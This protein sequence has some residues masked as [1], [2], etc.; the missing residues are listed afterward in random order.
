MAEQNK[1][2]TN[3][4]DTNVGAD[5][6]LDENRDGRDRCDLLPQITFSTFILSLASS[7]LVQLGEVPNPDTGAV[8]QDLQLAKHA[9]DTLSMLEEKTRLGLDEKEK[10]LLQSILYELKMKYVVQSDKLMDES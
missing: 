7:T 8:S 4:T 6:A 1:T 3:K 10:E 9:I 5:A 2:D